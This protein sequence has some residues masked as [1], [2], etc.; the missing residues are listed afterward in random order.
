MGI[1]IG[2]KSMLFFS[3]GR[4]TCH[5]QPKLQWKPGGKKAMTT[6]DEWPYYNRLIHLALAA[7]LPITIVVMNGVLV[8]CWLYTAYYLET[9]PADVM[10]SGI[11]FLIILFG[12]V[13]TYTPRF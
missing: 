3:L 5:D 10:L 11:Q 13:M 8:C 1:I 12:P 9:A 2:W 7:I 6:M 4:T